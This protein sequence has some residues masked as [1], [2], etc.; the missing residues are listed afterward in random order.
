MSY[1]M[2]I[3]RDRRV[4]R[5]WNAGSLVSTPESEARTRFALIAVSSVG[6]LQTETSILQARLTHVG[7]VGARL[8]NWIQSHLLP[9]IQSIWSHL[10]QV[11]SR[12]LNPKEWTVSGEAGVNLL[13]L[14][15]NVGLSITFGP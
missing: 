15:G 3:G 9:L 2:S 1:P 6:V 11:I 4:K 14:Q 13:G 5:E 12:M 10:W 8:T 7:A